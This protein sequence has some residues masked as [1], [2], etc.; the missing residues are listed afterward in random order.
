MKRMNQTL[1]KDVINQYQYPRLYQRKC[2]CNENKNKEPIKK[3]QRLT[4]LNEGRP[5]SY[6]NPNQDEIKSQTF[7]IK[8]EKNLSSI[9]KLFLH[10]FQNKYLYYA[11]DD[12]LYSLES[13]PVEQNNLL[14]ILYPPVLSLQNNFSINFF[15]IWIHEIYISKEKKINKFIST[16]SSNLG[17]VS[18]ITI[19]FL[20]KTATTPVK[21]QESLW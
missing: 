18:Y 21:K 7:Q 12:I 20:Y 4:K 19:Q 11:I 13:D 10:S 9:T 16:N 2:K 3:K 5:L 1:Y 17:S 8:Y 15:D 14:A 6:P